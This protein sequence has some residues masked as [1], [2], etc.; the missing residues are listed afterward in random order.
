MEK[1]EYVISGCNYSR[2]QFEEC[3]DSDLNSWIN[4]TFRN[5]Q[6]VNNHNFSLLTNAYTEK[7]LCKQISNHDKFGAHRQY[8]D[9]GGLQIITQG[10][11]NTPEIRREIYKVQANFSD[12]GMCFD[13]IPLG[14]AGLAS[15]RLDRKGRWFD[16]SILEQKA[17]ETG[18]NVHD[19]I[20]F[21]IDEKVST[22][23]IIIIQG[24]CLDTYKKWCEYLLDEIPQEKWKYISGVALGSAAFGNGDLEEITKAFIFKELPIYEVTNH[25]HLLGI[26]SLSRLAPYIVASQNGLYRDDI[27]ISYDST[28][29]SSAMFFGRYLGSD[30]KAIYIPKHF[31]EMVYVK[32]YN[33]I[34]S[35]FDFEEV[36]LLQFY[37]GLVLPTLDF[38][39]K[40]GSRH[41]CIKCS[42]GYILSSVYNF[43][44]I[45]DKMKD[46]NVL[47]TVVG[48]QKK[49]SLYN[50]LYGV[51]NIDDF[52]AWYKDIG[53]SIK[54]SKVSSSVTSNLNSFWE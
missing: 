32:L 24:N 12:I 9:S 1:Y 16:S 40:Y 29:H 33:E 20:N 52:N 43:T 48:D 18:K 35:L 13:E 7:S 10:L 36:P 19:Q 4:K 42:L 21:F 17:R 28:T 5:M 46:R 25:L 37:D 30:G 26:G 14:F 23:P 53:R 11:Q 44:K 39:E 41:A 27:L 49:Q 2:L 15:K 47:L 54:S 34:S 8:T 51:K 38:K 45:V 22:K 3:S 50:S 6:G 31:D